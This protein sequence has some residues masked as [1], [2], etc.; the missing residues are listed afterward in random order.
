MAAGGF[1]IGAVVRNPALL[2]TLGV[3]FVAWFIAF[4]GQCVGEAQYHAASR[5]KQYIIPNRVA[6]CSRHSS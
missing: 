1:D 5:G 2:S 3:A 4:I 6:D